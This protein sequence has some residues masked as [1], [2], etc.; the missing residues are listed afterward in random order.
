MEAQDILVIKRNLNMLC[1]K[2]GVNICGR[3]G[4]PS[5]GGGGGGEGGGGGLAPAGDSERGD[6]FI[7]GAGDSGA[8]AARALTDG[9]L[10]GINGADNTKID[11]YVRTDGPYQKGGATT[12]GVNLSFAGR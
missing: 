10:G 3:F 9:P 6:P 7:G 11:A 4:A 2:M 1:E 8:G 12:H 5:P